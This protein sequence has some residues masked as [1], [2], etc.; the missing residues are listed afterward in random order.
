MDKQLNT[1]TDLAA[2]GAQPAFDQPLHVGAP[3]IGKR[4]DLLRRIND[5][6]DRRRLTNNGPFVRELEERIA[7]YLGV[8]HIV[9]MNNGTIALE[10][11][12]RALNLRGEV[13]L[14]SMTFVATAHALQWQQ[15]KPVFCDIDPQTHTIDA[16]KAEELITPLTSGIIGVHLWGKACRVDELERLAQKYDLQ[17]MFDA[18]HAFGSTYRGKRIGGF[19]R[20]EVFSFHATKFFNT[21]EGGAVATNDDALAEKIRLMRNFG[22]AG[23][24][25][26]IYIG[27]NGKMDEIAAAM[28]LTSLE[29]IDRFIAVNK[30]NYQ[31]YQQALAGL[32][33][34]RLLPYEGRETYNYQYVVL[35]IDEQKTHIHRDRILQILTAENIIARR[36]FYPGCHRMEPYRSYQPH[37]GLMLPET[38]QLVQRVLTLP[39]GTA[40]SAGQIQ[41]IGH[42]IRFVLHHAGQINRQLD[43]EEGLSSLSVKKRKIA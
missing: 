6:L 9:A 32:N 26:V 34:I 5:M 8:K 7:R 39:T 15:I 40:V 31:L 35:E 36:Y 4:E 38:E 10:I 33:G 14:P 3:N 30:R 28:G 29:S 23:K 42:I 19:G 21:F 43:M 16:R 13:I 18:A 27:T 2:F 1:I 24:D 11:A 12:I 37:A 22:F 20:A 41:T 17:L 25:T